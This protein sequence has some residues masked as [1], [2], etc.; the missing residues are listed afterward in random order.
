V[1]VIAASTDSEEN[2]REL[3]RRTGATFP[4]GY[5]LP[6]HETAASLGAYYEDRRSILHATGF[7]LRPDHTVAVATYS[8]GPIGRIAPDDVRRLVRFYQ[9][10]EQG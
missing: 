3:A 10:Q 8:S 1:A 7:L 4:L 6:L 2:T 5:G 9:R